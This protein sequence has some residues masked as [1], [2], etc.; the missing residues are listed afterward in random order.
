MLDDIL[1]YL[2]GALDKPGRAVRGMLSGNQGEGLAALP[3]SDSLG[4]TNEHNAVS[5]EDLL[6][7]LFG[8]TGSETG[9]AIGGFALGAATDPL[10]YLGLGI[11]ARAGSAAGKGLEAAAAARGPGYKTLAESLAATTPGD[12][13]YKLDYLS[14]HIGFGKALDEIP[15]GSKYIG[16]GAEAMAF[17]APDGS[18]AR[19][20]RVSPTTPTRPIDPDILPTTRAVDFPSDHGMVM[21]VE[22]GPFA[23]AFNEDNA[24][25]QALSNLREK[26]ASRGIDFSDDHL[27][28]IGKVGG[29]PMVIDSGAVEALGAGERP[30]H[31]STYPEL[32]RGFQQWTAAG[33]PAPQ[34]APLVTPKAPDRTTKFLLDLIGGQ[35]AMQRAL[36]AGRAAP[37]Y[38]SAFTAGGATVGGFGA[39]SRSAF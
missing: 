23:S 26:L 10:S 8:S 22:R 4:I 17:Q 5:G 6:H 25:D 31:T 34:F 3:F 2:G 35:P 1:D 21:R 11:G 9:D 12:A 33:S 30:M 32:G 38:E 24:A 27:G 37:G 13:K 15:E 16:H 18:V 28:N 36:S 39:A 20:G 29:R 19:V 7:H 14:S